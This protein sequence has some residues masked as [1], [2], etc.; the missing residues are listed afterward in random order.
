MIKI[1]EIKKINSPETRAMVE[2]KIAAGYVG[3]KIGK[4]KFWYDRSGRKHFKY[5]MLIE[6]EKSGYHA[7]A[8]D[9]DYNECWTKL[10][11]RLYIDAMSAEQ[12]A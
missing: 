4:Y 12:V 9:F 2:K 8:F 10:I 5:S 11:G 1:D 6:D 7:T 3:V